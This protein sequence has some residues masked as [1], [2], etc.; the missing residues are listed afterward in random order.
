MA[1]KLIFNRAA[2]A[3]NLAV[4][5]AELFV[6]DSGTTTPRLTYTTQ[7]LDIR[8]QNPVEAD[9]AGVFPDVYIDGTSDVLVD[10]RDPKTGVSLPG[11][12]QDP[13][14]VLSL[15]TSGATDVSFAP[16]ASVPATNLQEAVELAATR[17]SVSENDTQPGHLRDK[18][19]SSGSIT[20]Q[21]TDTGGNEKLEI[22]LEVLDEGDFASN[23]PTAPPSQRSVAEY[24]G[25]QIENAEPNNFIGVS[26]YEDLTSTYVSGTVEHN[27]SGRAQIVFG[28]ADWQN[29]GFEISYD[30]IDFIRVLNSDENDQSNPFL[31]V[32]LPGIYWRCFNPRRIFRAPL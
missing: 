22:G 12:P 16:S 10:V 14:P 24:V 23:S 15:G 19:T 2:D 9:A 31:M 20:S 28:E 18:I 6:F 32:L 17:A 21:I 7:D 29:S 3:D 25:D 13:Y 1:D 26:Q 5:E 11:Y 8:H 4:A 27:T 30:N